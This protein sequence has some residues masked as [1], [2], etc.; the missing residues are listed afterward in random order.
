[1][2]TILIILVAMVAISEAIHQITISRGGKR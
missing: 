2:L 1:M